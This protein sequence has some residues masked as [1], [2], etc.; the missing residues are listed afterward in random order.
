MMHLSCVRTKG[1][2]LLKVIVCC[3]HC[4]T[5]W[6]YR[7]LII[8]PYS[9]WWWLFADSRCQRKESMYLKGIAV[10]SQLLA[11]TL[12]VRRPFCTLGQ[13]CFIS[14]I[15]G[16]DSKCLSLCIM[17]T[18]IS[19]MRSAVRRIF[20]WLLQSKILYNVPPNYSFFSYL[21]NWK[22]SATRKRYKYLDEN[23]IYTPTFTWHV[24]AYQTKAAATDL[25]NTSDYSYL[26]H[27]PIYLYIHQITW[28][29]P[30]SPF[31][32]ISIFGYLYL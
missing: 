24:W 22:C 30:F 14:T 4:V 32:L 19:V 28:H 23:L 18:E 15:K 17:W 10:G 16:K 9:H 13:K 5:P 12:C 6:I 2:H 21:N 11:A 20:D 1:L 31:S 3:E 29:R 25:Y 27:F 26:H 7:L 8:L